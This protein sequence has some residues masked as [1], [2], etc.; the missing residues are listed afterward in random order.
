MP[1]YEFKTTETAKRLADH[2]R[3]LETTIPLRKAIAIE[4][5]NYAVNE[6]ADSHEVENY[7]MEVGLDAICR[8]LYRQDDGLHAD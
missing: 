2:W 5:D 6:C 8:R 4:C 3:A 1:L 7:L